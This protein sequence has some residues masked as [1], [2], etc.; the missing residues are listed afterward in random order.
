VTILNRTL[1][2]AYG[3]Y[4]EVFPISPTCIIAG[5]GPGL[6]LAVA[7]R[8][9][10]EGFAVCIR[11]RRPEL[12][13]IGVARL[14]K[15]GLD[16]AIVDTTSKI[17]KKNNAC[18]VLVFNELVENCHDGDGDGDVGVEGALA[19]VNPIIRATQAKG[20]GA[21]LFSTYEGPRASILREFAQRLA[22]NVEPGVRIG[23]VTIGGVL[24][25]S[26]VKL[27]SIADVYW[28]LFFSADSLYQGEVRV[29]AQLLGESE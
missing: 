5:A 15:R 16:V 1:L 2:P 29:R 17:A 3:E 21:I 14:R 23:I 26:G 12:L 28:Q 9:A 10:R 27:K 18:D 4:T 7:E 20:D 22:Q 6:G 13:E 8:Y 11:T 24:P 19:S 25:T